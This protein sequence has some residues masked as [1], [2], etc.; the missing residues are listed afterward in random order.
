MKR[1]LITFNQLNKILEK[2]FHLCQEYNKEITK[3]SYHLAKSE[4]LQE[5][6]NKI[7]KEAANC[8]YHKWLYC[9]KEKISYCKICGV[10]D[11]YEIF[12]VR[13]RN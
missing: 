13:N 6:I 2:K 11:D 4:K 5:K 12:G 3:T 9:E 8:C 10:N 7:T 1:S